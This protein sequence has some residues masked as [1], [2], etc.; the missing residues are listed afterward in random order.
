[1]DKKLNV[2]HI[3]DIQTGFLHF[4]E[5]EFFIPN[6]I[7]AK[8]VK[9]FDENSVL[10]KKI[11]EDCIVSV[12]DDDA[13]KKK[14]ELFY[15]FISEFDLII[16]ELNNQKSIDL[17]I[18][19]GD[20]GSSASKDDYEKFKDFIKVFIDKNLNYLIV[21]GNHDVNWQKTK[22]KKN[23]EKCNNFYDFLNDSINSNLKVK[24]CYSENNLDYYCYFHN[25]KTELLFIGF[26]TNRYITDQNKE[27]ADISPSEFLKII[28]AIKKDLGEHIFENSKKIMVVHHNWEK[29]RNFR[30]LKHL[31]GLNFIL[32]CGGHMHNY[33]CKNLKELGF[34]F[35]YVGAGSLSTKQSERRPNPRS[36]DPIPSQFNMYLIENNFSDFIININQ[37]QFIGNELIMNE[38]QPLILLKSSRDSILK[39]IPREL[40]HYLS[41]KYNYLKIVDSIEVK[42]KEYFCDYSGYFDGNKYSLFLIRNTYSSE[43]FGNI[44]NIYDYLAQQ[45]KPFIEVFILNKMNTELL[46]IPEKFINRDFQMV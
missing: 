34:N 15:D 35:G 2:L 16:D 37:Y 10:Q 38:K 9:I 1:M 39:N 30:I 25:Q 22:S 19:S 24:Y 18:I 12:I 11:D 26:N 36:R 3:S 8:G 43:D 46:N 40:S 41:S 20:L 33:D 17:V 7:K 29:I 14:V 31:E 21:P 44:N 23:N 42:E 28:K 45:K 4:A 5:D 27:D 32:I 6:T 13:R